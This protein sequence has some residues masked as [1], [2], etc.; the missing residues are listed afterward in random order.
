MLLTTK[1]KVDLT[2][3]RKTGDYNHFINLATPGFLDIAGEDRQAIMLAFM[4]APRGDHH[5][6]IT[7]GVLKIYVCE[8]GT[9]YTAMLPEEY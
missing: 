5:Y 1:A 7:I 6:T 8:N 3:Y 2:E 9:G 4:S